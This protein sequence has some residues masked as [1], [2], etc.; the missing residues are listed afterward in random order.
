[1]YTSKLVHGLVLATIVLLSACIGTDLVDEPLGND[2]SRVEL[3]NDQVSLII[4]ESQQLLVQ[5]FNFEGEE[6]NTL[7]TWTSANT[8]VATVDE[9]GLVQAVASGQTFIYAI[10]EDQN[11]DSV[12]VTVVADANAVAEVAISGS[13]S[14]LNEGESI[15]LSATAN[16]LDGNEIT[17]P[18]ISWNSSQPSVASVDDNGLVTAIGPG[19]TDITATADGISSLPFTVSVLGSEYHSVLAKEL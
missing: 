3:S 13:N 16:N 15:Q 11:Q 9:D 10:A 19:S 14:P 17:N 2:Q 7:F 8:S 12:K 6:S 4:D 18:D 5:Y 1:M